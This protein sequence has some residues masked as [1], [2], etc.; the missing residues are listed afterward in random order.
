[1]ARRILFLTW[2]GRVLVI[3]PDKEP[4]WRRL[5]RSRKLWTGAILAIGVFSISLYY[6]KIKH[7][8]PWLIAAQLET[9]N[10]FSGVPESVHQPI[11]G[12]EIDDQTFYGYLNNEGQYDVT[13]REALAKLVGVATAQHAAVIALDINLDYSAIDDKDKSEAKNDCKLKEAIEN[14]KKENIPVVL[15]FGF[16]NAKDG[17]PIPSL[18][19]DSNSRFLVEHAQLGLP[20][21][22][23]PVPELRGGFDHAPDDRRKVPLKVVRNDHDYA[24]FALQTVDAYENARGLEQR[25]Q[26]RVREQLTT[27]EFVYPSFLKRSEFQHVSA[28][29]LLCPNPDHP[30]PD[31]ANCSLLTK[32]RT[33]HNAGTSAAAVEESQECLTTSN[34]SCGQL[35]ANPNAKNLLRDSIVLIGGNRHKYRDDCQSWVDNHDSPI[36]CLRGMYFQANYVEGLLGNR[37]LFTVPPLIAAFLDFGLAASVLILLNKAHRYLWKFVGLAVVFSAPVVFAFL[38]AYFGN[39]RYALDFVLPLVLLCL[40][41]GL[42]GY[43]D[44][45]SIE[46]VN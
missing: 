40:H 18:F 35:P 8:F 11:V 10:W 38:L 22:S 4:G 41:P 42:K 45:L 28:A 9:Y 23:S 14:A 16:Q 34:Q 46:R 7:G 12:V 5:L 19:L 29:D 17:G 15:V 21:P 33:E 39:R 2:I 6:E 27:G 37:I 1:M 20:D 3:A 36:G 31:D 13:D 26:T 44:L 25:T 43:I 30:K 32:Y 24:S